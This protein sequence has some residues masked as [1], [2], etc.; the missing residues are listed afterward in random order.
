[1]PP[2]AP[3]VFAF[4][5]NIHHDTYPAI[6]ESSH[7]GHIVFIS[8]ASKGIG[9]ATAIA[10]AKAGAQAIIIAARSNLEAVEREILAAAA[11]A[12]K[13]S[14]QVLKLQLD[15]TDHTA[16]IEAASQVQ[17]LFGKVDVLMNNAGYLPDFLLVGE[18]DP[19]EWWKTWDVNV[20]GVYYVTRELLPSIQQS[21]LRTI[22]NVSSIGAFAMVPGGSAYQITKLAVLRFTEYISLEYGDKGVVSY[23]LHP[24]AVPTELSAHLPKHIKERFIDQPELAAN[25]VAW[26]TQEQQQWLNGRYISVTW[27]MPELFSR[28]DE[29]VQGDKLKVKLSV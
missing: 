12:G 28:K 3:E 14:P 18:S 13:T 15:V 8:G 9:R 24:G 2:P 6:A 4:T 1:M 22:I 16:V 27:D 29:I 23:A 21:D 11:A 5:S 17:Q 19:A 10:F 26:L 20:K 7:H 25:A